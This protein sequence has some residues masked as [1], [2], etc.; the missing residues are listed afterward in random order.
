MQAREA[1]EVL[2]Q[3]R[4]SRKT[5]PLG[6]SYQSASLPISTC[7]V[8]RDWMDDGWKDGWISKEKR[9]VLRNW[10]VVVSQQVLMSEVKRLDRLQVRTP[11]QV[12]VSRTPRESGPVLGS[13]AW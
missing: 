11:Q 7:T 10:L 3:P 5:E 6:A 2:N 8:E 12:L 1:A 4:F 9:F 13:P